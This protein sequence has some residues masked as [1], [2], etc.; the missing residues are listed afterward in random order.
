MFVV[1]VCACGSQAFIATLLL[2]L[3]C[4]LFRSLRRGSRKVSYCLPAKG[5][6]ELGLDRRETDKFCHPDELDTVIVIEVG[7]T[8]TFRADTL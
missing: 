6:C 2:V 4:R 7:T 1:C 3:R 8:G 5:E